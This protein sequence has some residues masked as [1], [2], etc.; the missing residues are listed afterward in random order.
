MKHILLID[1][2]RNIDEGVIARDYDSAK[3]MLGISKWDV[4]YIDHD[5][6]DKDDARNGYSLI[7]T[8]LEQNLLS[9]VE[10]I[11]VVSSNPVGINNIGRALENHGWKRLGRTFTKEI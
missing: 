8:A 10:T 5:L 11:T 6:G 2:K 7:S 9:G 3:Y 1:D 4:I